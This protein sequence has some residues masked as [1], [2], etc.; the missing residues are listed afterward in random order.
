[1]LGNKVVVRFYAFSRHAQYLGI[2]LFESFIE[3][4]KVLPLSRTARGVVFGIKI[5]YEISFIA[6]LP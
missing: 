2:S 6:K 3:V 5:D 1:M 4:S